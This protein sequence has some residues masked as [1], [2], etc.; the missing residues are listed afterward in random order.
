[1]ADKRADVVVIGSGAAGAAVTWRLAELGAKVVCLEQGDWVKPEDYPSA[2]RD[3]EIQLRRGP[4]N[5]SPNIRQRPEDYPVATEGLRPGEIMMFNAVGGSTI[6]WHGH[7]PRFHPSD[8]RV[9]SLDGVADD[10]PIRYED[11]EPYY[12]LN[13][14]QMGVSGMSGDPANPRRVRLG[15]RRRCPWASS[16]R[17]SAEALIGWVGIGGFP[18]SP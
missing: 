11:L 16:V 7:F 1:M 14:R 6:H 2:R 3:Y 4:F 15:Q 5:Y 18:T 12:D 17:P 10:W 13:D 9:K 8:F